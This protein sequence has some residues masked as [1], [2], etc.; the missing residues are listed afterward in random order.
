MSEEAYFEKAVEIIKK[1]ETLN[2]LNKW[3]FVGYGHLVQKGEKI[4]YRKLTEK[5]ADELLRKDLR[6]NMELFR[7]FGKDCL[8][9]SVLAY[10]VGPYRLLGTLKRSTSTIVNKLNSG[11]RDIKKEYLSYSRYNG[12]FHKGLH[13]RR[14]EEFEALYRS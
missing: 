6:E 1:Y 10:N 11:N 3:P 13:N 2:G 9:L 8:L 14:T 5:E 12:R 4:P 7:E